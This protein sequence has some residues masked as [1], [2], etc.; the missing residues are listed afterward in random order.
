V[1]LL[2]NPIM[3]LLSGWLSLTR[4]LGSAALTAWVM[5]AMGWMV[6]T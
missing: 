4:T 1:Q 6:P 5:E 3:V 2:H